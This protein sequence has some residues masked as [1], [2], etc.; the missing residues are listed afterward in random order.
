M[1]LIT[2]RVLVSVRRLQ[3]VK[4]F[5]AEFVPITSNKTKA[6]VP[7]VLIHHWTDVS[8]RRCGTPSVYVCVCVSSISSLM[9]VLQQLFA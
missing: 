4:S 1:F 6:V 5:H 3:L 2:S 7:L 8:R 9:T